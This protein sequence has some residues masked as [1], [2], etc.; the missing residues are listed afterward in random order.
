MGDADFIADYYSSTNSGQ[1]AY[2]GAT[3]PRLGVFVVDTGGAPRAFVGPVARAYEHHGPLA[4]RLTDEEA[5][6]LPA[7]SEP[8][9]ASYTTHAPGAPP[10]AVDAAS[11][12]PPHPDGAVLVQL[13]STRPLGRV[14]LDL[15][16]HHYSVVRTLTRVVGPRTTTIVI[17]PQPPDNHTTAVEAL[18]VRV[19]SY[20]GE[21]SY[22]NGAL[23]SGGMH[24][25]PP[26]PEA[27]TTEP[28]TEAP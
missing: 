9:A 8:W 13:H 19:G 10:L 24:P 20:R 11:A 18:R 27:E 2:A 22:P 23:Y 15:L 14:S 7:V 6:A 1:A 12:G 25:P 28:E 4:H 26:P 16:N 3:A 21:L 5:R 17:P